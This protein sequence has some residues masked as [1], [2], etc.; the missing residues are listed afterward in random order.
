MST[1]PDKF[2]DLL[3]QYRADGPAYLARFT[4]RAHLDRSRCKCA[5]WLS[6]WFEYKAKGD[7]GQTVKD[8]LPS[9]LGYLISLCLLAGS[10][11]SASDGFHASLCQGSK[12]PKQ[13]VRPYPCH[14]WQGRQTVV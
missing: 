9:G 5:G 14:R 8:N 4:S 13:V 11:A 1:C 10:V 6:S 7:V 3:E 12:E 2:V